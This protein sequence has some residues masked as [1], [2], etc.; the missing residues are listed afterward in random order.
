[1]FLENTLSA[2]F[3]VLNINQ[4][5]HHG[6]KS[7][8]LTKSDTFYTLLCTIN[9]YCPSLNKKRTNSNKK[10]VLSQQIMSFKKNESKFTITVMKMYCNN[11]KI[12]SH[13]ILKFNNSHY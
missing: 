10:T 7:A 4:P 6:R 11:T 8:N 1:M 2:V 13:F 5:R 12:W 9:V 3:V